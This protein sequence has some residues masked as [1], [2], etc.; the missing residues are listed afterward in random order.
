[1]AWTTEVEVVG[2][3]AGV[4]TGSSVD[5]QELSYPKQLPTTL[6]LVTDG[7]SKVHRPACCMALSGCAQGLQHGVPQ[8]LECLPTV[9]TLPAVPPITSDDMSWRQVVVEFS[10]RRGPN[11]AA[12]GEVFRPHQAVVRAVHVGTGAAA[13][14]RSKVT[15]CPCHAS[16][17]QMP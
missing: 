12:A 1:V 2:V 9:T 5:A 15:P 7:A 11:S 14:F 8:H 10:V 4:E 17:P 3:K 13:T 16:R 6:S